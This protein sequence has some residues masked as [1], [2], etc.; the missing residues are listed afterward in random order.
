MLNT[1]AMIQSIIE[2]SAH[3]NHCDRIEPEYK[4]GLNVKE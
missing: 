1:W 2:K 3:K 4:S